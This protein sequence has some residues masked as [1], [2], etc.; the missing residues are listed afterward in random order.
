[1]ARTIYILCALTSI[2]CAWL[3]FR[4]YRFTH[5]RLLIWSTL[6][7]VCLAGTNTLLFIDLVV[8]P[9][10]DLSGLRSGLTLIGMLMLLYGLIREA[11]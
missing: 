10:V 9:T 5:G 2:A 1:M 7:F 11:T 6:C 3:L 4:Q 8:L